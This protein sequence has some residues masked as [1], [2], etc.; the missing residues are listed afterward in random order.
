MLNSNDLTVGEG[1][2]RFP[3]DTMHD[4]LLHGM[5]RA[6]KRRISRKRDE[7]LIATA[8][9]RAF[10]AHWRN[11]PRSMEPGLLYKWC[12]QIGY[13][14]AIDAMRRASRAN[15]ISN[16]SDANDDEFREGVVERNAL[17]REL[18]PLDAAIAK[19]LAEL[20]AK[21]RTR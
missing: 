3:L 11:P 14:T 13:R 18:D 12:W 20:L 15:A 21:R 6:L 5:R 1:E 8:W 4:G 16:E 19:E 7:D 17:S 9:S 10:K 2:T